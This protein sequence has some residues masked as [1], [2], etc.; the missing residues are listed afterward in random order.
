MNKDIREHRIKDTK[1]EIDDL[2]NRI[3]FKE[4]RVIAAANV[5]NYKSCDEI[6]GEVSELKTKRRELEA[7][8]KE[9][10][11]KDKR[12]KNYLASRDRAS[13]TPK[14]PF[15]SDEE[16]SLESTSPTT[17]ISSCDPSRNSDGYQLDSSASSPSHSKKD[18]QFS[19]E[20]I[21]EFNV[22]Y[23]EGYNIPDERYQA[24]LAVNHPELSSAEASTASGVSES[25]STHVALHMSPMLD[26]CLPSLPHSLTDLPIYGCADSAPSPDPQPSSQQPF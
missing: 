23:E 21:K 7:E 16:H 12:A 13:S 5:K 25:S 11:S 9:L 1:E 14:S 4:K 8:L 26:Q 24:W 17:S 18:P 6:T 22:R 20:E 2:N 19:A 3:S 10:Q 15:S